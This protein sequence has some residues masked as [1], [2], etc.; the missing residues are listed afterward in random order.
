[1]FVDNA[2]C[3]EWL[4]DDLAVDFPALD[5]TDEA[6]EASIYLQGEFAR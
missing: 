6:R 4:C 3:T 2:V 1:M 5:R